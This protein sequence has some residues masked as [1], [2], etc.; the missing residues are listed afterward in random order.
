ME[1]RIE[2]V[3]V[4]DISLKIDHL[5]SLLALHRYNESDLGRTL[6]LLLLSNN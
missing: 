1:D 2:E 4:D 3:P 5:G 6:S